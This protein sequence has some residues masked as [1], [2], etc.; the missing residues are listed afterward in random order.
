MSK[1]VLTEKMLQNA[2]KI[3][4]QPIEYSPIFLPAAYY[5][6]MKENNYDMTN[7][8]KFEPIPFNALENNAK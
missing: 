5:D 3:C 7:Y 8:R 4:S 1:N 2:I 6:L